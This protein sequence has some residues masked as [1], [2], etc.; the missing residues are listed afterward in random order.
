MLITTGLYFT[1]NEPR[2]QRDI[3]TTEVH[4]SNS[5]PTPNATVSSAHPETYSQATPLAR[6]SAGPS[7]GVTLP[8]S[9]GKTNTLASRQPPAGQPASSSN[10]N[11]IRNGTVSLLAGERKH[12]G[13]T[14][15]P[16]EQS[17]SGNPRDD[18]QHP[19]LPAD[20]QP[21]KLI[22]NHSISAQPSLIVFAGGRV[23][24]GG[25]D[26]ALN[27]PAVRALGFSIAHPEGLAPGDAVR[28]DWYVDGDRKSFFTFHGS[29][30]DLQRSQAYDNLRPWAGNY[31]V[32]LIVND[33]Q[34]ASRAFVITSQ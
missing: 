29:D 34:V 1:R 6:D 4:R 18:S 26:I 15:A 23:L 16:S 20:S 12:S 7:K 22:P 17:A 27:D 24:A 3:T 14:P 8:S 13:T 28:V 10:Q 33:R 5:L 19:S 21:A 31:E 30:R 32:R 25:E 9:Q 11:G 2:R